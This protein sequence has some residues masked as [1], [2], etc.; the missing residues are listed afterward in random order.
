MISAI[1]VCL[2]GATGTVAAQPANSDCVSELCRLAAGG[3]LDDLRWPDF[4]D[5]RARVQSFYAPTGYVLAWSERGEP[6]PAA[7]AMIDVLKAAGTKGLNAD[8]Y[9]GSRW[10]ERVQAMQRNAESNS[11]RFDLALTV[12]TMRY[13]SDLHFGKAN[14]GLLHNTFDLDRENDD[15][16]SF[17]RERLLR[18]ASVRTVLDGVEP[19]YEGYK[20][21]KAVLQKYLA[22]R[23][24][25]DVELLPARAKPIDPGKLYPN[26]ARL[27]A[28]LRQFGDLAADAALPADSN[29][30]A[31]PLVDAVKHFQ[32][33][34]G[35]DV[36]GRLGKATIA[37]LNTP[38]SQRIRQLQLSL[39]RWRWVPHDFP[40]PPIVV[41]IPEFELRALDA[42]YHTELE[43]KVI[44]G[45]SFHHQTPV[46]SAEMNSVGFW[47]YWDVPPSIQRAEMVPKLM[48]DPLYLKKNDLIVVTSKRELVSA[49]EVDDALLARLRSFELRIRQ[50]PGPKNSLGLIQF[51]FPNSYDIY[52]HDTPAT[53]LFSQTRRD[54]SHGCIRVEKPEQLA[55]WVL[56]NQPGWT[57]ERI[58]DAIHGGKTFEVRLDRRIPVLIVYAT[59][60]VLANGDVR[61]L[62]DIYGLDAQLEQTLAK[63]YP[64]PSALKP[65]P[66]TTSD[67][68][69]PRPRE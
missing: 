50:L 57:P 15:L 56:R 62:D 45:K 14:P 11:A 40:V 1:I 33:R 36:D 8:D 27:A 6:T 42:G 64:Y 10:D 20:R 21:T 67:V 30:Y 39:E 5:Y 41:N 43:M 28:I 47:P 32:S 48:Q 18:S 16:A 23:Q 3:R 2:V 60:V 49:G 26:T 52:M 22:M 54:F 55:V 13:I 29:L 12:C 51:T 25:D 68:R 44:V 35:L 69:G 59:A 63:G 31:G 19:P 34:H 4:S 7:K 58:H 37:Q 46:F 38:V 17:V 24:P 65:A 66:K 53:E 9:D 61:F